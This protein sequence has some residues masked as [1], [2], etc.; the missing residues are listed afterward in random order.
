MKQATILTSLL[1]IGCFWME[2]AT[3]QWQTS[4]DDIYYNAGNIGIGTVSTER[5]LEVSDSYNQ[6][7]QV[8]TTGGTSPATVRIHN[9]NNGQEAGIRLR[10]RSSSGNNMHADIAVKGTGATDA[11]FLGFK[12]PF[13]NTAG[14]GYQMVIH[15]DGKVGIGTANPTAKLAVDGDIK[16]TEII[17]TDQASEWPDYVFDSEYML[18]DLHELKAYIRRH[19]HLPGI[20][21]REEVERNGQNV[22]AIQQE[23]LQKIEELTL[24]VIKLNNELEEVKLENED[25]RNL[26]RSSN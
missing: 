4:G 26:I 18:P 15:H 9:D 7:F 25:L 6:V 22:G 10:A 24:Y 8:V 19:R 13:N 23:L 12:V 21:T 14:A 5:R 1:L 16:T 17:V 11:G 20:P 2:N 3:A